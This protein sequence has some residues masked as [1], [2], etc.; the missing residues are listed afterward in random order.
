MS[1]SGTGYAYLAAW[2]GAECKYNGVHVVDIRDATKPKEVAFIQAKEG[3][4]PGEGI[5]TINID[6]PFVRPATSSSRTTR[7]ARTRPASAA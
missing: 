3:S 7:S 6:T 4:A 5:Q 1:A 2:G